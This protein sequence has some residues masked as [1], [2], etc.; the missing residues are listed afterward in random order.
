MAWS[1]HSY[2]SVCCV[3]RLT[4]RVCGRDAVFREKLAELLPRFRVK[5]K[6][7]EASFRLDKAEAEAAS[8]PDL[9]LPPPEACTHHTAHLSYVAQ[10]EQLPPL[11]S[12]RPPADAGHNDPDAG[13]RQERSG[14]GLIGLTP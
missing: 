11:V 4:N 3:A 14:V 2:N 1:G 9:P 7:W 8:L 5:H 10:H 12:W 6:E 13:Q